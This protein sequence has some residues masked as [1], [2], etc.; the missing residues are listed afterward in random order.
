M[1]RKEVLDILIGEVDL[2]RRKIEALVLLLDEKGVI[3]RDEFEAK[4]KEVSEEEKLD[5]LIKMLEKGEII[6][7]KKK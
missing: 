1:K 6:N 2:I 7:N 4:V 5:M 3:A